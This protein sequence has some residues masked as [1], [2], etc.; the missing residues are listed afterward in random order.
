MFGLFLSGAFFGLFAFPFLA[1]ACFGFFALLF[2]AGACFGFFAFPF[3]AGA[4]LR[5]PL[6]V[7]ELLLEADALFGSAFFLLARALLLELSGSLLL[8]AGAFLQ[9]A[10]QFLPGDALLFGGSHALGGAFLPGGAFLFTLGGALLLLPGAF[11][12]GP[13]AF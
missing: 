13:L 8:F 10:R 12:C 3:L 5:C 2:E 6:P 1:G 9:R 4:S 7:L 11:L